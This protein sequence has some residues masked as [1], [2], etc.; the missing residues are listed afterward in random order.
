[1]SRIAGALAVVGGAMLVVGGFVSTSGSTLENARDAV[2][3]WMG[4]SD[5][6]GMIVTALTVMIHIALLGGFAVILGGYLM[7][8]G[9]DIAG[10]VCVWLGAGLGGMS[11]VVAGVVA[12]ASGGWG[13]FVTSSMTFVGMGLA[14]SIAAR[15]LA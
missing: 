2:S 12:Y 9:F 8:K 1:M 10:K 15:R 5:Q 11:L 4:G 7:W 13:A 3:A 6:N 14:L